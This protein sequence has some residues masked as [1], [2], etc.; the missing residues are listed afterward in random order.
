MNS[1]TLVWI[2]TIA[3]VVGSLASVVSAALS[4]RP[5]RSAEG[6]STP[7]VDRAGRSVQENL[8]FSGKV[9]AAIFLH[10]IIGTGLS[11]R[12]FTL[13]GLQGF[14]LAISALAL[15]VL[16]Y[17]DI[18]LGVARGIKTAWLM[19]FLSIWM[20]LAFAEPFGH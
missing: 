4:L 20:C 17:R 9:I 2:G 18:K 19:I 15:S 8:L 10:G 12:A 14:L 1:E 5:F 11:Q 13:N 16:G 3:T 6:T 7:L